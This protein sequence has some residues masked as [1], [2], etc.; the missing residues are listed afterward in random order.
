MLQRQKYPIQFTGGL[1]AARLQDWHVDLLLQLRL[2]KIFFAYDTP[3]DFEP[4]INA[5]IMLKEIG[6][7]KRTSNIA[8]C[9]VL[10]GYLGDSFEKAETR[11]KQTIQLGFMPM[12][13]L[14]MK[15]LKYD[16]EWRRFQREWANP[17][18]V[19]YIPSIFYF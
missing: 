16:K 15:N 5:S 12:A 13:M 9:F 7:I 14:Y 10:I 1:E 6:I 17:I 4:L 19:G 8:R 18:I 11:L 3:D 2:K